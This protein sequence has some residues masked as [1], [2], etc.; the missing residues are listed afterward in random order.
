MI[1]Y[2]VRRAEPHDWQRIREIRLRSLRDS[3]DAFGTTLAHDEARPDTEW[4]TRA[5]NDDVAQF[6]ATTQEGNPIGIAVGAPYTD[7]EDTAGLFAMWV[8]PES[9]GQKVGRA[10]VNAVVSWARNENYKRLILDVADEN[11]VAVHLYESC[12]F[13]TT[14]K[15]ST[16]PH[17]RQHIQEHERSLSLE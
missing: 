11:T 6:L 16:L 8:A 2:E 9:R 1:E 3:P 10:I 12:G 15:T 4:R 17:P 13:I 7:Y 5:E 14:G